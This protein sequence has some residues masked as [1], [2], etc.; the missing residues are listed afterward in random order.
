MSRSPIGTL[1]TTWFSFGKKG[2][3]MSTLVYETETAAFSFER[4]E[5]TQ[6]L[7]RSKN[8]SQERDDLLNLISSSTD[9]SIKIP[10]ECD[11]FASITLNLVDEGKGSVTCK[12]CNKT[13]HPDQLK[14]ITVGHG[15][16]PFSVKIKMKGGIKYLF[17]KRPR[18]PGMFGGK[19]Y[20]CPEGH[21]LI[22]LITWRT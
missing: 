2:G 20:A 10:E 9:D 5:I 6:F 13:Y 15:K 3:S 7:N 12:L 16:T 4:D 19:G 1:I 18:L 17:R 8:T 11:Y 14:P 22:T 21:R